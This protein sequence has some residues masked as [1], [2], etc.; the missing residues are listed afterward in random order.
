MQTLSDVPFEELRV[1]DR[2]KSKFTNNEGF[3]L[4]LI[5]KSET[6]L[7]NDNE[8][9]IRWFTDDTLQWHCYYHMVWLM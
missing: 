1:G 2:V 6:K 7:K 5:K 8:I 3:I 9:L 4:H